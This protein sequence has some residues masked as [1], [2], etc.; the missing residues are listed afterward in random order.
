MLF[1]ETSSVFSDDKALF[2]TLILQPLNVPYWPHIL[3]RKWMSKTSSNGW[4]VSV[5]HRYHPHNHNLCHLFSGAFHSCSAVVS[6]KYKSDEHTVINFR[7]VKQFYH[8]FP[9]VKSLRVTLFASL[10]WKEPSVCLL[11]NLNHSD[12][13]GIFF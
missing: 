2:V 3:S 13:L 11:R 12:F 4:C 7:S 5:P 6:E 10:S 8:L 9:L 1:V